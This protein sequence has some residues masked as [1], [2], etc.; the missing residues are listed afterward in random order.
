[1]RRGEA[2]QGFLVFGAVHCLLAGLLVDGDLRGEREGGRE[3]GE[4][5]GV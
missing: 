3:T 4:K 5:R 1:M 2:C